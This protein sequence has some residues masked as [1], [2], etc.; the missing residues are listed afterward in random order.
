MVSP[1]GIIYSSNITPD[2]DT[3]I[4]EYSLNDFDR[5]LRYG[6]S[7]SAKTLYPAMPYPS[8]ARLRDENVAALC[9]FHARCHAGACR[10]SRNRDP[11]AAVDALAVGNLAKAVRAGS[12]SPS[13]DRNPLLRSGGRARR[14]SG[15]RIGALQQLPYSPCAHAAGESAR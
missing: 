13:F 9:L 1:I 11:L 7:P 4:G 5:A 12:G 2:R 6:I 8:Y 3:G 10:A 15:A 14:L